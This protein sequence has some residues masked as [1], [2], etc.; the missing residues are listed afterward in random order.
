MA[1]DNSDDN[2]S[3]PNALIV[4]YCHSRA[5]QKQSGVSNVALYASQYFRILNGINYE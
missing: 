3:S 2:Q 1:D 4:T 5:Q